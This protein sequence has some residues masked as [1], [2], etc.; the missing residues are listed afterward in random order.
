MH[1]TKHLAA[2]FDLDGVIIDTESQYSHIWGTIGSTFRPDIENFSEIIKG[3]TL[4]AI[5]NKWFPDSTMQGKVVDMLNEYESCMNYTYIAG[6]EEYLRELRSKGIRTAL[7]TSSNEPKMR[8]VRRAHEGFDDFFD[9]IVTAEKITHSKPH[10]EC[11]LKAA[12]MLGVEPKDCV[13]FEDS[14][15]GLAAGRAAEM[16]VVGLATTNPREAIADKADIIIDNFCDA[17]CRNIFA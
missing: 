10:P 16:T 13:V 11:F 4:T 3:Q 9:A 7:V 2:L 17:A 8:N 6:A 14:F 12:E 15:N 5:L 1:N